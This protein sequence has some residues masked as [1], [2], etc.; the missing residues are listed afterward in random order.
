MPA[1]AA[2]AM[3]KTEACKVLQVASSAD[4]E[5]VTQAYWHLARK[6][7]A[8]ASHDKKARARLDNLNR[9]YLVLVPTSGGA[10]APTTPLREDAEP[11]LTDELATIGRRLV[12]R[13]KTRWQGRLPELGILS[14]TT[15]VLTFLA[16]DAGAYLP[17][18]LLAAACAV[19]AFIAPWRNAS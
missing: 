11:P 4:E 3:N 18:V 5:I 17:L 14:A 2:R 12:Q 9:A 16:I 1:A 15:A 10:P 13:T 19:F 7:R 8:E 6:Y